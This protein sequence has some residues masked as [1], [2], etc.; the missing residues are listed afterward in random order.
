MLTN[1]NQNTKKHLEELKENLEIW[2]SQYAFFF[3][4]VE[5]ADHTIFMS[6]YL[7]KFKRKDRK[8]LQ[9]A[10]KNQTPYVDAWSVP[11]SIKKNMTNDSNRRKHY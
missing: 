1:T 5:I 10:L 9:N 2:K 4:Y 7:T 6:K 8:Y 3:L 11:Q